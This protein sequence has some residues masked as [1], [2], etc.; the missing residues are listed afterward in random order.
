MR[1][2]TAFSAALLLAALVWPAGAGAAMEEEIDYLMNYIGQSDCI[3][4]RNGKEHGSAEALEHIAKK[5]YYVKKKVKRTEDFIAWA[6]TKSSITGR[7][8]LVR[9]EGAEIPTGEWLQA[10]L[11]R[12]RE[13]G[14]P[15]AVPQS[16]LK[17]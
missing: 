3:F 8:Y 13:A 12:L 16:V 2:F 5:Y 4:V 14:E 1:G 17:R 15:D 9:C 7:L 6:A 10:E 11:A